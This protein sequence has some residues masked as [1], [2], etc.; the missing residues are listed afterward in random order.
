MTLMCLVNSYAGLIMSV[1][2]D[3]GIYRDTQLHSAVLGCSWDSQKLDYSLVSPSIV[4]IYNDVVSYD[5]YPGVTYYISLWYPRSERAMRVAI[6]FSAA[7]VA[8]S[9]IALPRSHSVAEPLS[10]VHSAV[11]LRR[12]IFTINAVLAYEFSNPS[13]GIEK[14]EG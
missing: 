5:L 14:M 8:G 11:S 12:L 7:T 1:S 10:K 6:F 2:G 9:L 4:T 3:I 13:Y